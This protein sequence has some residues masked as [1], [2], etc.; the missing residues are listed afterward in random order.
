MRNFR[1]SPEE[2]QTLESYKKIA[3][4]RGKTHADQEFWRA[5]FEKF[6]KLLPSGTVVDIGCGS[7]RDALLLAKEYD[8]VGI[9]ASDEMLSGARELVPDTDF[10]IMDMYS[11]NFSSR[12]IDGFWATASLLHIP[13]RNLD[14]VLRE[15]RRVTKQGGIGFI[16]MKEGT[17]ERM[18]RGPF[19]GDERF[20]AFYQL[21]EFTNLLEINGFGVV[22][23]SRD[24]HEY[25][26]PKNQTVWLLYFVRV[27]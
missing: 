5:E 15:I 2:Q 17:G 16:A 7:G 1:L 13:K 12:S 11:L 9:D 8:Y 19:E 6:K 10:R 25:N 20:F 18:V 3:D 26:Q 21:Q 23:S 22:E 27:L 24:V 14:R 4:A